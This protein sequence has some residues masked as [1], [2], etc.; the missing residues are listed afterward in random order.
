M[1]APNIVGSNGS[2]AAPAAPALATV[3]APRQA[4]ATPTPRTQVGGGKP[5]IPPV[6]GHLTAAPDFNPRDTIFLAGD[7][8]PVMSFDRQCIVACNVTPAKKQTDPEGVL[9][10]QGQLV[11]I[12][13]PFQGRAGDKLEFKRAQVP[14]PVFQG[15]LVQDINLPQKFPGNPENAVCLLF[16]VNTPGVEGGLGAIYSVSGRMGLNPGLIVHEQAAPTK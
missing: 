10:E 5:P 11:C 1:S 2:A 14:F 13:G 9:P 8:K 15:V 4:Q 12:K 6:A 16:L 3:S 7:L